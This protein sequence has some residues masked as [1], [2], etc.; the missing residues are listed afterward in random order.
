MYVSM[1]FTFGDI[2]ERPHSSSDILT[3]G[4]ENPSIRPKASWLNLSPSRTLRIRDGVMSLDIL[5]HPLKPVVGDELVFLR[6]V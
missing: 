2:L 4:A 3:W 6:T 5:V 1:I